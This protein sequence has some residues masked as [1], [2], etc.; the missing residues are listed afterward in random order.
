MDYG[1][2]YTMPTTD[3]KIFLYKK[4]P[5]FMILVQFFRQWMR[6]YDAGWYQIDKK[7]LMQVL[8]TIRLIKR[9]QRR[10]R[11]RI[12]RRRLQQMLIHVHLHVENADVIHTIQ[13]LF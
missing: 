5:L 12:E 4:H 6:R 11:Q 3:G 1:V 10:F 8:V 9:V 2:M 7:F 13:S